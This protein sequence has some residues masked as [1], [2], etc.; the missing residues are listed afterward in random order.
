VGAAS[1][2]STTKCRR[3]GRHVMFSRGNFYSGSGGGLRFTIRALRGFR[4]LRTIAGAGPSRLNHRLGVSLARPWSLAMSSGD[5]F[6]VQTMK[7]PTFVWESRRAMS[8][9]SPPR[10]APSR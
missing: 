2:N 3:E 1:A 9:S 8:A 5:G 4:D 10:A 6:P 7:P